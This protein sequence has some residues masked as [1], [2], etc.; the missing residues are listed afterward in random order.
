MERRIHPAQSDPKHSTHG[1]QNTL[2]PEQTPALEEGTAPASTPCAKRVQGSRAVKPSPFTRSFSRIY[3]SLPHA[4]ALIQKLLC[5]PPALQNLA[6]ASPP[7]P[8]GCVLPICRAKAPDRVGG[9][10]SAPFCC[11]QPPTAP[12]GSEGRRCG[13]TG[14]EQRGQRTRS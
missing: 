2:V 3:A 10:I 9:D 4:P 7:P 5:Q 1:Q 6:L 8:A 14:A 13:N 12:P 11:S